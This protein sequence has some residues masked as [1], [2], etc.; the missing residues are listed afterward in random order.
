MCL[1]DDWLMF[2]LQTNDS[3]GSCMNG[4]MMVQVHDGTGASSD[5]TG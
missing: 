4:C 1:E 3:M 2:L 5:A